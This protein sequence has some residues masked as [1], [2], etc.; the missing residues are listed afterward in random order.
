M[1]LVTAFLAALY[2]LPALASP[3]TY[4]AIGDSI[5]AG[6]AAEVSAPWHKYSWATGYGL[7]HPFAQ[8]LSAESY[9]NVALPGAT[10]RMLRY[11]TTF[12]AESQANYVSIMAGTNDI[13]WIGAGNIITNIKA[14]IRELS[15]YTSVQ[16][17][18]VSSIPDIRQIYNLRSN[19]Y[20][21]QLPKLACHDY[22]TGTDEYRNKTDQE[23]LAVNRT[24]WILT[25][26][27]SKVVFV[28]ITNDTYE[29]SD[30]SALDCFHP[31]SSGQ[32]KIA[33]K[34]SEAFTRSIDHGSDELN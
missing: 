32:Q 24:L 17:I 6:L 7:A 33:D 30:I 9:Y 21:C 16:K 26:E 5:T 12:S 34:F 4:V 1:K 19:S 20:I 15:A 13:C 22:F 2:S 8:T 29:K 10:T 23:I 18:F 25:K 3:I 28:D 11:Q 31:S 14:A 27:Y